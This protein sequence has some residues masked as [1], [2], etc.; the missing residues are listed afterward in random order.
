M[1]DDFPPETE[2][3]RRKLYPVFRAAIKDPN[4]KEGTGM[5]YDN[6]KINGTLY[7]VKDLYKLPTSL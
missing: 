3:W 7:S 5:F 1:N 6:M 4:I 2:D